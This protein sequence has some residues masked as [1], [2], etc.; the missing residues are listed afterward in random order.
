MNRD[1]AESR[2]RD[3]LKA[4]G[5]NTTIARQELIAWALE[6][7]RLLHEL[8]APHLTGITAHAINHVLMTKDRKPQP[9]APVPPKASAKG[10]K[11]DQFGMEILKAIAMGNPAQFGLEGGVAIKKQAASQRHVDAIRAMVSKDKSKSGK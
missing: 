1:Y 2:I 9:A 5:G 4:S 10:E 11:G 8:V 3:A 6:D 7:N